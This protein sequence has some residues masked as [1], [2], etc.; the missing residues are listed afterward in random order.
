MAISF[1]DI[2]ASVYDSFIH[3][4]FEQY[5]LDDSHPGFYNFVCPNPECGDMNFPNKKKAY[6][7]TD[8][9]LYVCWKCGERMHFARWLKEHDE[10]A[11]Q[12][13]LFMAFGK[14]RGTKKDAPAPR[15]ERKLDAALPFKD[16]ELM[17]IYDS[18][19]LA[20]EALALCRSR[21]IR[22]E[23]YAEWFVCRQGEQFYDRDASGNIVYDEYGRPKGN[24]YRNRIIIPFYKFG[25]TW[26]QFDARAIDPNNPLRYRNF[27]GVK[28]GAYNI[29]FINYSETI[30]IL[31]GTIDSTFIRNSIA[32]GGI[33]HFGEVIAENPQ[34]AA[35]KD[36]IVV[37][38][39]ND[40]EGRKARAGTTCDQGYKWFSWE[41]I[42]SKDVNGAVMSGEFPVNSEGYVDE[43]FL[44]SRTRDPEGASIIF[45]MKYGNM[46]KEASRKRFDALKAFREGRAKPNN[47]PEVL[48]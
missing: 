3:E 46:K 24:E 13:L 47:R 43:N 30:Y 29:D 16:G 1:D 10:Q 8:T 28:R 18:D 17:S 36:K 2:P 11:Y 41:G 40:P 35:N 19:P 7:Y 26:G 6:I 25:G 5:A 22:E 32:I 31:E 27:T 23:V 20:Q 9:W 45:T 48:F 21:R 42:R 34:L 39:D 44:K 38:W 37:L 14:E 33:P 15:P 12:R 4:Q